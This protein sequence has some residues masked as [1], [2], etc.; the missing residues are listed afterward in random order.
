MHPP[1]QAS[2]YQKRGP[3]EAAYPINFQNSV[4]APTFNNSSAS[5][6]QPP[7]NHQQQKMHSIHHNNGNNNNGHG[8]CFAYF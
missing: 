2:T 1:P 7:P 5:L 8:L 6:Y 4:Q 3:P